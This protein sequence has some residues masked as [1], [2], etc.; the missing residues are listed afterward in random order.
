MS[1]PILCTFWQFEARLNEWVDWHVIMRHQSEIFSLY[2]S[3][4]EPAF[5]AEAI[6][7]FSP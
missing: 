4:Y 6:E 7:D 2:R 1:N 5:V 3:G